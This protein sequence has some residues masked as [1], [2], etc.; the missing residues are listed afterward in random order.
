MM[1]AAQLF[2]LFYSFCE[3]MINDHSEGIYMVI[4]K[5]EDWALK[6]KNSPLVMRRGYNN[7]IDK[8]KTGKK[9]VKDET[10]KYRNYFRQIYRSLNKYEGEELYKVLSKW[11]DTE[12]YM[13]WLAFNYFVRNGDYTDEVYFFPDPATEKFSIIPWDYDDIFAL[14]PHE[15]NIQSKKLLEGKL[16]FSTEDRLD[17]KIVSDP[18]LYKKYLH[19]FLELMNQLSVEVIKGAFE[20]TYAELYPYYSNIEIISNSKYDQYKDQNLENLKRNMEILYN[21]LLN[22]REVYLK[23]LESLNF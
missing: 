23:Y 11:L 3:L 20:N 6:K 21:Q 22:L 4:E 8:I 9:T 16:F 15:G 14:Y 18:Y 10:A 1:E 17:E 12:V 7:R 2:D 5:P 19:Q 13:K